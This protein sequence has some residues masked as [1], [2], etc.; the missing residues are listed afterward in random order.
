MMSDSKK[1]NDQTKQAENLKDL[2]GFLDKAGNFIRGAGKWLLP[3][4]G[5]AAVTF[6]TSL[7]HPKGNSKD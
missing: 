1:T 6:F 5:G 4:L 3:V 7:I 2:Y